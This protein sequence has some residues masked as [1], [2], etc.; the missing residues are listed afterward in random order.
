[1][2]Q[3]EKTPQFA[4]TDAVRLELRARSV[5]GATALTFGAGGEMVVRFVS[6]VILARLLVPEDF[7]LIGIVTALT[8]I[9][10]M[11]SGLGLSTA[12]V[13]RH[14]INHRQVTNLFWI[15]LAIGV[16]LTAAFCMLAPLIAAFY[17]DP[18]LTPII[19]VMSTTFMWGSCTVQ[20]EALL[21][22]QMQQTRT[23][24]IRFAAS[25]VSVAVAIA[26][27][28][29]DFGYWALV[30]Q[31][32]GRAFLVAVGVWML[33]AWRPGLPYR[34]ESVRSFVRFGVELTLTHFLY[35]VATNVDR[36]IV[37][38][39]F[40]ASALGLYRQAHQLIM[41]PI[42]QLNQPIASVA[43]PGLSILQQDAE[44]Y[45]RYYEKIVFLIG[46]VTMPVSALD[47]GLRRRDHD[48]RSR[49]GMG[50]SR[51]VYRDIRRCRL[52]STRSR[53]GEPGV[54]N[55]R[56]VAAAASP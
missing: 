36:L 40:G 23:A 55:A 18:R 13:Q 52:R 26:L 46:L 7:G 43:Q 14:E 41:V 45:R 31:E 21:I 11:F 24:S 37:G 25:V 20:H 50:R 15:N 22:R 8:A 48:S 33:C 30:W 42:E 3:S 34:R 17:E 2:S 6:I 1:M 47:D 54:D 28:A 39:L 9:A 35:V 19:L 56:Q 53:V 5:R 38:K 16:T 51:A 4:S 12:T 32:V 29:T 27:A 10:G 44:R 49:S